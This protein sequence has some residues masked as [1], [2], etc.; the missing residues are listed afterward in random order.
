MRTVACWE[1]AGW[2]EMGL[3]RGDTLGG[4]STGFSLR[5]SVRYY[6]VGNFTSGRGLDCMSLLS[7]WQGGKKPE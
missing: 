5:E 6:H 1:M 3:I 4:D 2:G 7:Q